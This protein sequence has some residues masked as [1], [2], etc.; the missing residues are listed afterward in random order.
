MGGH[1]ATEG[2]RFKTWL[3]HVSLAL[4]GV[5]AFVAVSAVLGTEVGIPFDTTY[6]VA[7]AAACLFLINRLRSDYPDETWPRASLL[8][9]LIVNLS[10]FLTPLVDR[11]SSRGELM[12]FALP[13]TVVVLAARIVSYRVDDVHQRAARQ[14]ML[15]GL[16]VAAAFCV[17]LFALTLAGPHAAHLSNGGR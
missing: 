10:I 16:F 11:P 5:A 8:I 3:W 6:R 2:F 4:L 12:L 9:A 17:G 7:C 15:L 1:Q 14:T 13:D